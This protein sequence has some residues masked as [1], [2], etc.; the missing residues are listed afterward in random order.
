MAIRREGFLSFNPYTPGVGHVIYGNG[1]T[2]PTSGPVSADG[3][4]GYAD[5]DRR[6]RVRRNALL[7]FQRAA[8]RGQY[9]GADYSRKAG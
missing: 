9:A 5:R 2:A 8:Q 3:Q 4:Q 1:T 6:L 7:A